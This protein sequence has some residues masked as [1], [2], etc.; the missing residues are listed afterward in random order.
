MQ[1]YYLVRVLNVGKYVFSKIK[2]FLKSLNFIDEN[3][4]HNI[5]DYNRRMFKVITH[6]STVISSE[7]NPK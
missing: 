2:S 3:K 5:F 6:F 1:E 4:T 7:K